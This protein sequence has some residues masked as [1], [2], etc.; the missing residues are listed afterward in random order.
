MSRSKRVSHRG[1]AALVV[2]GSLVASYATAHVVFQR[3]SLRQWSQQ[4][5]ILAVVEV[6]APL[7]VWSAPD[8]SDHQEYFSARVLEVI[9]GDIEPG[10][11]DFFAH[12]EGEPRYRVG[13]R[14]LL[15][16]DR[17]A[18]HSE[19]A[20]LSARFPLFT[21]QGAGQE[22]TFGSAD[23]SIVDAA[24]AWRALRG[25]E[26]YRDRVAVVLRQLESSDSRLQ[27]EAMT[28]LVF[29]GRLPDFRADLQSKARIKALVASDRVVP[30]VR[31]GLEY[32]LSGRASTA[33]SA[34]DGSPK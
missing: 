3:R 25:K 29:L 13:D 27:V 24:I 32:V 9:D 31:R 17:S 22:W 30:S 15:F 7:R 12:A 4:A 11:I 8:G 2:V 10:D 16:L 20:K 1:I 18:E 33:E 19:F 5:R 23:R 26:G 6:T 14:A 34:L 28:D 21:T